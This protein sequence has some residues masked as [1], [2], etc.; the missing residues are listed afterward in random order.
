MP[1]KITTHSRGVMANMYAGC[2]A[3]EEAPTSIDISGS[4][5]D[6][7]KGVYSQ[8]TALRRAPILL[9]QSFVRG[10]Y[11]N[12]FYGCTNLQFVETHQTAWTGVVSGYQRE[13]NDSWLY[14]VAATGVFRCPRALG[15]DATIER[16]PSRCPEGW[17]VVNID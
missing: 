8:C 2:T 1:Q 11:D 9:A 14:G 12:M 7:L 13:M 17:T 16:G 6:A 5:R 15:T 10:A 3:L 4:S